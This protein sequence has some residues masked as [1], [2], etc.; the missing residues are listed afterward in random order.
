MAGF[1]YYV[2]GGTRAIKLADLQVIG[3]GYA[4]ERTPTPRE[5]NAGPDNGRGV[6]VFDDA[7]TGGVEAGFFGD[8]QVWRKMLGIEAWLGYHRDAPPSPE[9]LQREKMLNGHWVRLLDERLWLVPAARSWGEEDGELRWSYAVPRRSRRN[10]EGIWEAGE[11]VPRYAD[12]WETGERWLESRLRAAIDPNRPKIVFHDGHERSIRALA[13]N[14]AVGADEAE[15]LDLLTED[16]VRDI[17]DAIGDVPTFA[18]W[19]KKRDAA[20]RAGGS[21]SDGPAD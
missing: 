14:Y 15:A 18:A 2:P 21:S 16:H 19:Q 9:E 7:R 6:V 13:I 5:C 3:L 1:L 4:F 12:L 11:V 10:A 8:R 17:L 20:A